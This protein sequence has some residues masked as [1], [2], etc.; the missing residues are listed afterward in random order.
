[1]LDLGLEYNNWAMVLYNVIHRGSRP[2]GFYKLFN[3]VV[4]EV[5][6]QRLKESVALS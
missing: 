4:I 5:T 6:L 3:K 1:M 2:V